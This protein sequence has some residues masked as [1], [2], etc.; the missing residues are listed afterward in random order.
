MRSISLA[1]CSIC[2]TFSSRTPSGADT[3]EWQAGQ[4]SA[5]ML[6]ATASVGHGGRGLV[7]VRREHERQRDRSGRGRAEDPPGPLPDVPEVEE[8]PD[9]DDEREDREQDEPRVPGTER[10]REVAGQHREDDGQRQVVV[11]HGPLLGPEARRRV[12]L[13]P[14]LLCPDEL[15]VRRDDHE[16]DVR[17]HDRPEHRADLEERRA[18]GEELARRVG[19]ERHQ[20]GDRDRDEPVA[21]EDAARA[22]VHE[23]GERDPGGGEADRLHRAQVGDGRVDEPLVRFQPVEDDEEREAGE[24]RRVRLPLEPV[25]VLRQLRRRHLVLLRVVEAAAVHAPVLAGDSLAGL[26]R[27]REPE[28]EPDEVERRSDPRDPGDHVQHAAGRGRRGLSG[29]PHP[30]GHCLA[31]AQSSRNPVS[32]SSARSRS[33]RSRS[34]GTSSARVRPLTKTTNPKPKRCS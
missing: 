28:V 19:R 14:L 2:A 22:V 13:P 7:V 4:R 6:C 24:P 15:P 1:C 32:S 9:R 10:E 11:V 18:R 31:I 26:F 29:S 5:T 16:E 3:P 33:S 12:R 30:P 21:P 20:H 8:V 25:Q 27:R 23:P 17:R 34:T